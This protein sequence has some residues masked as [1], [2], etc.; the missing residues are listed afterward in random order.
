MSYRSG[1]QLMRNDDRERDTEPVSRNLNDFDHDEDDDEDEEGEAIT[2]SFLTPAFKVTEVMAEIDGTPKSLVVDANGK[3]RRN[4][5]WKFENP[6]QTAKEIFKGDYDK[7]R[8]M[9]P[10]VAKRRGH[11]VHKM[12]IK[13]SH[14]GFRFP[15]SLTPVKRNLKQND[16]N[17]DDYWLP[18]VNSRIVDKCN[19]KHCYVMEANQTSP[20]DQVSFPLYDSGLQALANPE[21][22]E[23][24]DLYHLYGNAADEDFESKSPFGIQYV[25][26]PTQRHLDTIAVPVDTI[27]AE[28][29]MQHFDDFGMDE[30]L[31]TPRNGMLYL[32][33]S[34]VETALEGVKE[35][36]DAVP[37]ICLEHLGVVFQR[38]GSKKFTSDSPTDAV[39]ARA[40]AIIQVEWSAISDFGRYANGNEDAHMRTDVEIPENMLIAEKTLRVMKD[41]I[42]MAVER[43]RELQ[44]Q[45]KIPQ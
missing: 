23:H 38:V 27:L 45:G 32:Y 30:D 7:K 13:M 35:I 34:M 11:L 26:H 43:R 22:K 21:D 10:S 36:T 42:R 29:I 37:K 44:A 33:P 9:N 6:E 25:S 41:N 14:N 20:Y 24:F 16:P 28:Y 8:A 4:I 5:V 1:R 31:L 18:I 40:S 3:E 39:P 19:N 17:A 15:I 12:S 2:R